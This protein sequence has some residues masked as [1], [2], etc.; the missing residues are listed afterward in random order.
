MN[1]VTDLYLGWNAFSHEDACQTPLWEPQ[2]R[3]DEGFRGRLTTL[4]QAH[5]CAAEECQHANLFRRFTVRLVCQGCGAVHTI[6]GEDVG[7]SRTT[8]TLIGYGRNA[9]ESEGLW[10]WPGEH[11]SPDINPEPLSWL[12]T[13]TPDR[14][15]GAED[16]AGT[17]FRHTTAGGHLRFQAS[18]IP[19]PTG[20]YGDDQLRWARRQS[21]LRSVDKAAVWIAAQYQPQIVEVA[22]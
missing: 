16:V 14:P 17:I 7:I 15:T 11:K 8:T 10:M 18:A 2:L 6:S 22:V 19:D 21:D 20:P 12:I 5:E 1:I 9:R 13:R 4:D 3:I